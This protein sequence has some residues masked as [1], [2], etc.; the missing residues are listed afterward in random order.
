MFDVCSSVAGIRMMKPVWNWIHK[1]SIVV[2]R[3]KPSISWN[4]IASN[5]MPHVYSSFFSTRFSKINTKNCIMNSLVYLK[6]QQKTSEFFS[7]FLL[8][9]E[10]SL[11][12]FGHNF[13]CFRCNISDWNAVNVPLRSIYWS[14]KAQCGTMLLSN[15]MKM[16]TVVSCM[17]FCA[18]CGRTDMK[19]SGGQI[20]KF[21]FLRNST[22]LQNRLSFDA[23]KAN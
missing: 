18:L 4:C 9:T 6:N 23:K 5:F 3:S 11:M 14:A 17:T 2:Q 20:W 16:S 7:L 19:C 21:P 22:V 8:N 10:R 12:T 15:V 1:R 13:F